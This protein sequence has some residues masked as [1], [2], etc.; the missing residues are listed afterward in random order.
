MKRIYAQITGQQKYSMT[1]V[2]SASKTSDLMP[3]SANS[4]KHGF[5]RYFTWFTV[6]FIERTINIVEDPFS[7]G[8]VKI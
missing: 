2:L 4:D 3:A 8:Q 1:I 6:R 5:E 7:V